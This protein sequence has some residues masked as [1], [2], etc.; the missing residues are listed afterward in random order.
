MIGRARCIA[1]AGLAGHVVEVEAHLAASLPGFTIVGLADASLQESRDRVRAA[2]A[3]SGLPWP[4]RR[5][6]VNLSPA[7][8]PKSGSTTDLA[9]A[10][11]ILAAAG[12]VDAR[13]AEKIRLPRGTRPRRR[14][15][16]G[17]RRIAI[18]GCRCGGWATQRGGA[19][20]QRGRGAPRGGRSRDGGRLAWRPCPSLG[21]RA[22]GP[23]A[24][25]GPQGASGTAHTATPCRPQRRAW[26]RGGAVRHRG[27][28]R[29][30]PSPDD[31]WAAGG[32]QDNARRAHGRVAA[33]SARLTTP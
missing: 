12:E 14:R 22:C 16:A 3:S 10:V 6:T 32:W 29:G 7:S 24:G 1:L 31:G 28:G 21:E 4:T 19:R 20:R 11:A 18:G 15:A 8:L 5:I 30:G 2:V 33:G 9:I 26:A 23:G 17:A 25:V 27:G 13:Q